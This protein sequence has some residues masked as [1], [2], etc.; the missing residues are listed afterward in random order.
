MKFLINDQ[1]YDSKKFGV[2]SGY[3]G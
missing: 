3:N 2:I 1:K